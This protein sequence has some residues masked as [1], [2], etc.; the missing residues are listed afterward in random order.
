MGNA[1][2]NGLEVGGR[3]A[4]APAKKQISAPDSDERPWCQTPDAQEVV[5]HGL[6]FDRIYRIEGGGGRNAEDAEITRRARRGKENSDWWQGYANA[7]P[8]FHA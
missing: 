8:Q 4:R 3:A 6:V 2:G 1:F 5:E 7:P